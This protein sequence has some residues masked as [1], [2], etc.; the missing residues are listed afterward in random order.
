MK[1]EAI[2]KTKGKI[3]PRCREETTSI[4]HSDVPRAN[5]NQNGRSKSNDEIDEL[6]KHLVEV[7]RDK[8]E[9]DVNTL[10]DLN[11]RY[12]KYQQG[13][14]IAEEF[15]SFIISLLEVTAH[16]CDEIVVSLVTGC[17]IEGKENCNE[18]A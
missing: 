2:M 18:R 1:G 10:I 11:D 13:Q 5:I 4:K 7:I 15:L 9:C 17:S 14:Y 12:R 8:R 3:K 16:D 6:I